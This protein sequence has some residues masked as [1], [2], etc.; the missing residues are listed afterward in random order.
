MKKIAIVLLAATLVALPSCKNKNKEVQEPKVNEN[1]EQLLAEDLKMNAQNLMESA[2]KL[3][4]VPFAST[5]P[6]GKVILS[7]KE[8]LVKPDYLLDPASTNNLVT[9]SQKYRAISMLAADLAVANLYEMPKVDYQEAISRLLVD[10]NDEPMKTFAS[11]DW[12]F[13]RTDPQPISDLV[14]GEYAQDRAVFFWDGM[15]ASFVEQLYIITRDIDKY[16]MMFTDEVASELTF[17]FV[18]VHEGLVQCI[19]FYPEMEGLNQV[20]TPLYVINAINVEQLREQLITIK[21]DIEVA[22]EFLLK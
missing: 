21:S 17:N 13:I 4:V 15:A 5:T 18:C 14:D 7:D 2:K 22:R 1:A 16:M 3:K 20:L 9:L 19:E 11:Y 10:I 6:D 8:K 12:E